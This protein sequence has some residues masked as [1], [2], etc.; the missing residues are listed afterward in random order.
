MATTLKFLT[1]LPKGN[2]TA[3]VIFMHGLGDSGYGWKPIADQLARD[4]SFQHVKWVLPH[5]PSI[6]CTANGGF[7]MPGWFDIISFSFGG[8]EDEPGALK[9][10]EDVNNFIEQEINQGIPANRIVLG[11]FSQ[12]GAMS[13]VTGLT[14]THKLAGLTVLSGWFAI[15]GKVKEL[16]GQHTA[17]IPIFWGHGGDDPLVPLSIGKLSKEELKEVGVGEATGPGEPG[18]SFNEYPDLDHA[19]DMQEIRDW[20]SWLKKVI[21]PS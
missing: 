12:G 6:P 9:S 2:H 7:L 20:A 1:V 3:T 8:P 19:A 11:G 16:L 4:P 13:L 17:A 21:P 15:R 18:I 14:S 10:R 5:A